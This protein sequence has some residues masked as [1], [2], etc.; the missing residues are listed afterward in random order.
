MKIRLSILMFLIIILI[1]NISNATN[2]NIIQS[3][4]EE[5]NIDNFISETESIIGENV[6]LETIFDQSIK[7]QSSKSAIIR[8]IGTVL[9]KELRQAISMVV[10][11]L[12]IIIVHGILKS[13]SE[14]LGNEQTGKIGYF[15]Q[16][17]IL[18]TVLMK[19]YSE[20]LKIVKDTITTISSFVYML[21]PLF[22]SLTMATGNVTSS[23][24]I[25]SVILLATNLITGFINQFLIPIVIIATVIGIISNISDEVHMNKLSKYMKSTVIW[26]LC[27]FLT[28]FTC[29][30]T[31]ESNLTQGVD[32]LASKTTK[33]AVSTFVPVVGKILGDTVESVLGCSNIIKNAV[34][35]VGMIAVFL[36]GLMP[37]VRIGITMMF[38]YFAGGL[39]EMVSDKKIV[40]VLEQMGDSCKV[41]L[42][43]VATVMIMLIIGV[44]IS[45]KIGLPT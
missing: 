10:S 17:I 34:G 40:Y 31:M 4:S 7:G 18:I 3:Q 36:I 23:A 45:M 1:S 13:V 5:I 2:E 25:Q 9:G 14:N 39:A 43:A 26:V 11:I 30:L 41:L 19:I 33:T 27:I 22:I 32:Q 15:I 6:N 28:I 8:A 35:I 20:I 21:I 29:I 44:T 24:A 16:I 12:L 37:L 38:F 42:A